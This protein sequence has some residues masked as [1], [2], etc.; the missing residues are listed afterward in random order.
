MHDDH[1]I[2]PEEP[3]DAQERAGKAS[4]DHESARR[5]TEEAVKDFAE[6]VAKAEEHLKKAFNDGVAGAERLAKEAREAVDEAVTRFE[7][8]ITALGRAVTDFGTRNPLAVGLSV[9]AVASMLM[10]SLLGSGKRR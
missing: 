3:G 8:D 2:R 9:I 6:E 10:A 5:A 7:G 4:A 1:V